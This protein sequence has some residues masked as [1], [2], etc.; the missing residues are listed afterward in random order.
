[1]AGCGRR[2]PQND[3]PRDGEDARAQREHAHGPLRGR[4]PRGVR[5]SRRA[6]AVRAAA[7]GALPARLA[8]QVHI[9]ADSAQH[10]PGY[11]DSEPEDLA[12][13]EAAVEAGR[14]EDKALEAILLALLHHEVARHEHLARRLEGEVVIPGIHGERRAV[15]AIGQRPAV[16]AHPDGA[17]VGPRGVLRV[18]DDSGEGPCGRFEPTTAVRLD[19]ARASLARADAKGGTRLEEG[20]GVAQGLPLRG[21]VEALGLHVGASGRGGKRGEG[22]DRER[23]KEERPHRARSM[24]HSAARR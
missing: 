18:E 2:D 10:D 11:T 9:R 15:E 22:H 5:V 16:D 17:E 3:A 1:M 14:M 19:D 21:G 13:L 6:E 23:E 24:T 4:A 12:P 20:V 7:R 8:V